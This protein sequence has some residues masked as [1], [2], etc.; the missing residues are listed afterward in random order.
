MAGVWS[1]RAGTVRNGLREIARL[2]D[3]Q[4]LAVSGWRHTEKSGRDAPGKW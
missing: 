3:T 4:G 1:R 2:W